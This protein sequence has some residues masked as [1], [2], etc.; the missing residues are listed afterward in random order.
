ME[1]HAQPGRGLRM[2]HVVYAV[3]IY[4]AIVAAAWP[5]RTY[6]TWWHLATGR[7]IVQEGYV[8]HTD[9]FTYTR[10]GQPWITHE[11]LWE[12]AMYLLYS[13]WGFAGLIALKV[14]VCAAAGLLLTWLCLRRGATPLVVVLVG[15]LGIFAARPLFNV[16]P[17]VVSLLM[18]VV[19]LCLIQLAREGRER[20]LWLAPVVM[21]VWANLHGGFIFGPAIIALF[22]LCMVP[23]WL[24]QGREGEPLSPTPAVVGGALALCCLACLANPNG[25]AG[26]IYPLAYLTGEHSYTKGIVSEYDS[27][28]FGE[29]MWAFLGVYV[30]LIVAAFALSRRRAELFDLAVCLVFVF[31]ALRWERNV[32]LMAFATAPILSLHLTDFAR[33]RLGIGARAA[34]TSTRTQIAHALMIVILLISAGAALPTAVGRV[35]E[36]FAE[37]FPVQALQV[38]RERNLQGHMFNTYHWGGYLIW[39][40]WPEQKVF[41]D[42]RADVMGRELM[43]DWIRAHKLEPGWR[44]VLDRYDVQ[45]VIITVHSPLCRALR[46]SPDFELIHA[47]DNAE[48]FVRRPAATPAITEG[49]ER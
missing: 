6:D 30:L 17:Q 14:T 5:R 1:P 49:G 35:G 10:E 38:V 13:R 18:F 42:G 48:L 11:W 40:L 45:W 33:D 27:P 16:R 46:I 44:E 21:A 4:C 47:D 12:L 25:L 22:G 15:A 24:R 43:M 34:D 3:L 28:Q 26:A 36:V 9:P 37:D 19:M 2:V 29:A 7:Y 20:W 31:I 8:P 32:A 23:R 39:H 41:I